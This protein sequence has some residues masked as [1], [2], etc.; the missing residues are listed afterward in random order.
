MP[1]NPILDIP[2]YLRLFQIYLGRRI[3]VIVALTLVAALAEGV[4]ILMLLPLLATLGVDGPIPDQDAPAEIG[5]LTET[6]QSWMGM[7]G[8]GD[9]TVAI[10][11]I[12]TVAFIAKGVLY[13]AAQAY[14]ARLTGQLSRRL[15]G[16]LFDAYSRMSYGYY[17]SRDTG[18]FT[19]VIIGQTDRAVSSFRSLNQVGEQLVQAIIYLTL[20]FVVAW[21][22][23]LMALAVGIALL[24]V[25][26][27]LNSYVRE[28][29][30]KQATEDGNLAK[31]LIQVLHA[32][33]YLTA[34]GQSEHVRGGV[35]GSIDRLIGYRIRGDVAHAFTMALRE[36][37]AVVLIMLIVLVQLVV[38][39]EPIAP[40]LVSILLFHRGLNTSLGIQGA[41]QNMLNTVGSME[42]VHGEFTD[43]ARHRE[44]DGFRIAGPLTQ[45]ITLNQVSFSYDPTM[46]DVL[47]DLSLTI[48]ARTSVA[49]VGESGA[50]KSTL[51]DLITL[52]LKPR[53][54]EIL[55][56]GIPGQDLKLMS[57]RSQ[58]GYVS[59][60]TVIFDDS[61]ANN[62]CLWAGDIDEDPEL[63]ARVR[64]AASKAHIA[65]FIESLPGGY[66]TMVGDRGVRLSGGQRQRLFIARE[67]FRN[68]T[69]LI[70]DE[71]TSALDSESEREIQKS[72]D[73]LKGEI[74][75]V[76]IAHRLSTIRNVD[77]VYVLSEGQLVEHGAYDYLLEAEG[78]RFA[79]LVAMQGPKS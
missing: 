65:H 33:K 16:Q 30:R 40:I 13:F 51:V 27:N 54:G 44:P 66:H 61:V 53:S 6:F 56:D 45:G 50:G 32:F 18:H 22:F 39:K 19:N 78:S 4:G 79:K 28:L 46:G 71:A 23:G 77:Y 14:V 26:R 35:I 9:S 64:E 36:P 38:L 42:I 57:W 7:F 1:K 49:F 76:I 31:L 69:L 11:L 5:G 17:A 68:P 62:V 73:A 74:T 25:F 52:M 59:Q 29:S 12:I 70:L 47:K 10:L 55:I 48:Q 72:I 2:H 15:K 60:E 58:V 43:Q 34:T 67:L 20:A 8:F 21:R 3:Y 41:L 37:L 24:F 63:F 75:V